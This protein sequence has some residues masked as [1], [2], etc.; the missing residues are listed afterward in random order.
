M[1]HKMITCKMFIDV[2]GG[3]KQNCDKGT[4]KGLI[5]IIT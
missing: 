2:I 4:T 3:M 1:Y 5:D